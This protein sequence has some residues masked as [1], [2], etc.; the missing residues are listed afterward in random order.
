M[1]TFQIENLPDELYSQI[2]DLAAENNVTLNE[3]VIHLLE[4]AC[5][6]NETEKDRAHYAKSMSEILQE[7]RSRP[8]VNPSDFG[9]PDSTVLIQEDR[10]R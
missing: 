7:I 4:Q 2:Q 9:L 6:T 3:A 10:N 1:A 8:R 5:Q